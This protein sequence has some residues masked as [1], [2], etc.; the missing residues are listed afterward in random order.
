[1]MVPH[2]PTYSIDR[3]TTRHSHLHPCTSLGWGTN[4]LRHREEMQTPPWMRQ[5]CT[6]HVRHVRVRHQGVTPSAATLRKLDTHQHEH[7]GRRWE[8]KG[9]VTK[10][11]PVP[12][13]RDEPKRER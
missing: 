4:L 2:T 3:H 6:L 8:D 12:E 1:M 7:A 11:R 13:R 9:N 5:E 10:C